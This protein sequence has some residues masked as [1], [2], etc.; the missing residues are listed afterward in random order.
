MKKIAIISFYSGIVERGVENFTYEISK[1]LSVKHSVTVFCAGQIAPEKF[2]VKVYNSRASIPKQTDG[3]LSKFYL[4]F[5]SFK[6]MLFSLK[7][8]P[9]IVKGKYD[10]IIPTNGGWQTVIF[11]IVSKITKAKLL[12]TGHAGIGSDDAWNLFFRPDAFV[13]L[14][15]AQLNW[16][17]RLTHEVKSY[18]I[19]NGVDLS[20]FNPKVKKKQL[21]FKKPI[22]VCASALVPYKRVDLTVKAVAKAGDMSL[23]VLGDGQL[24]GSIDSLGR[25]LLGDR[26]RRLVVPY[27]EI[28]SYYRSANVFTLASKTEAFGISYLEAMACNLPVVTTADSSRE[29]IIGEAGVLTDPQNIEKYAKDLTIAIKTRYKNK[30]YA[31][32]LKFSWNKIAEEYFNLIKNLLDEFKKLK[33]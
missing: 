26:Y 3:I 11:R 19:P 15:K 14:T 2:K 22:V 30:P 9:N 31:Q 28:A 32:A 10:L 29:E 7:I 6:I 17:N 24:K 12:I 4:D 18:L 5:Q 27:R 20:L 16:A 13:A 1:R 21:N 25:R 23:L 33:D 8:I